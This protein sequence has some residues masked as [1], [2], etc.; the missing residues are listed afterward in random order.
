MVDAS[1]EKLQMF[2]SAAEL[3]DPA[4]KSN[5]GLHEEAPA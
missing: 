5:P 1:L 3:L 4:R 2:C